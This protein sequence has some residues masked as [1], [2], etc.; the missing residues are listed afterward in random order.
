MVRLAS[1]LADSARPM[2]ERIAGY[3]ASRLEGPVELLAG[4]AWEEQ[5]RRL[6]AGEI[7]VAFI[8]GLPYTQKHDRPDQPIDIL[9]A[10]V[11]AGPRYGGH[12]VYFT[13]VVVRREHPARAFSDLRGRSWAYSDEGSHS[14]YNV[15][16][17]H[18]LVLG[19][20]RGYFGRVVASGSQQASIQMVLDGQVEASGID[21][22][23]LDLELARR[24]G[25]AGS[26][27]TIAALGPSPIPPAVVARGL[28]S[29]LKTR[30]QELFLGMSTDPWG[31]V[32]LAEG[33]LARFVRVRDK[34]YDPIRAM[35]RRA[36]AAGF[37]TI[38]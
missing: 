34:D 37:V 17:H 36:E 15:M 30:L 8:C 16:R 1:F 19:E 12:P 21:S 3:L 10:P 22:T 27:R 28:A 25:L 38:H 20:T 13:D 11:M 26:L 29:P 32:I 18:L 5:H 4:V 24:P 2:Y 33:R 31:R 14:G 23:V 7:D 35:V 6:D 9:C